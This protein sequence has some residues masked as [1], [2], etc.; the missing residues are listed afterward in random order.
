M[1]ITE[2]YFC[3]KCETV[4]SPYEQGLSC[5]CDHR[6]I[7]EI[8]D[9][10]NY[11]PHWKKRSQAVF[12]RTN[13]HHVQALQ[14]HLRLAKNQIVKYCEHVIVN[15]SG[16]IICASCDK[17]FGWWCPESPS[18]LCEFSIFD[19][20]EDCCVHCHNSTERK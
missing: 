16:A 3:E 14:E 18:Y 19:Y 10:N 13:I 2:V 11:P 12:D 1:D 8:Y 15:K 7:T 4:C 9:E 6:W 20:L 17:N 5:D